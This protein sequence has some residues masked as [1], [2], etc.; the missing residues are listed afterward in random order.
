MRA[1]QKLQGP[2]LVRR[3][4]TRAYLPDLCLRPTRFEADYAHGSALR[5]R[6][7]EVRGGTL[8]FTTHDFIMR[9]LFQMLDFRDM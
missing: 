7:A 2:S 6:L 9:P 8:N 3:V 4:R 1:E 5:P